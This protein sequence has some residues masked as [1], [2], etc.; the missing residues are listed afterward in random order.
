MI[1]FSSLSLLLF[2]YLFRDTQLEIFFKPFFWLMRPKK[3]T[4]VILSKFNSK[5]FFKKTLKDMTHFLIIE[6]SR[7]FCSCSSWCFVMLWKKL[8]I[9]SINESFKNSKSSNAFFPFLTVTDWRCFKIELKTFW[10]QQIISWN[11][12]CYCS[13]LFWN[14]QNTFGVF[15]ACKLRYWLKKQT[16]FRQQSKLFF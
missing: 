3:G 16:P 6:K 5:S 11:F 8:Y 15:G 1:L 14:S 9:W 4:L 12:Q 10:R 7:T 2:F 13:W